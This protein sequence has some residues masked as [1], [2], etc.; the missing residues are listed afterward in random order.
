MDAKQLLRNCSPIPAKA[1]S[2]NRRLHRAAQLSVK[3]GFLAEHTSHGFGQSSCLCRAE[4]AADRLAGVPH[5]RICGRSRL[6]GIVTL[7]AL[8][9]ARLMRDDCLVQRVNCL[10]HW[11]PAGRW[12]IVTSPQHAQTMMP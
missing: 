9:T 10:R 11:V 8:P 1:V 4:R 3:P 2:F 6:L 7:A 5:S 12:G